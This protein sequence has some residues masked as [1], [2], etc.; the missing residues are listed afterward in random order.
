[1]KN[2]NNFERK[3]IGETLKLRPIKP[4]EG[5]FSDETIR[6]LEANVEHAQ[7]LP[8]QCEQCG[9]MVDGRLHEGKW[10]PDAHWNSVS[11]RRPTQSNC[12]RPSAQRD[13]LLTELTAQCL[14][15]NRSSVCVLRKSVS[16]PPRAFA[17]SDLRLFSGWPGRSFNKD[18]NVRCSRIGSVSPL[19]RRTL[20]GLAWCPKLRLLARSGTCTCESLEQE[21]S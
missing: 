3:S 13:M 19:L 16:L 2:I 10:I 21:F 8:H 14:R 11:P 20:S 6:L 12:S 1:M 4:C 5:R 9:K 7:W 15:K 18:G 17:N